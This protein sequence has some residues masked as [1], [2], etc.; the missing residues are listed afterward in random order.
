MLRLDKGEFVDLG[1]L[2]WNTRLNTLAES[3][4][5]GLSSQFI[6]VSSISLDETVAHT[7]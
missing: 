2:S 6:G 5:V 7:E 4:E 1:A 3:P